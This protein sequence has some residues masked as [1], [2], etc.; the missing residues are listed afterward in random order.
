MLKETKNKGVKWFA[1]LGFL[2]LLLTPWFISDYL[3]HSGKENMLKN[4]H[5][6]P[7]S[8]KNKVVATI[9]YIF[10]T[11]V[12]ET[13]SDSLIYLATYQ[14]GQGGYGYIGL[15]ANAD[16]PE[17]H[18]L[19]EKGKQNQEVV[20]I[21]EVDQIEQT[22]SYAIEGYTD[23]MVSLL[24]NNGDLYVHFNK[25]HYLS[26]SK[27]LADKISEKM[28]TFLNPLLGICFLGIAFFIRR[29]NEAFYRLLYTSY[30]ELKDHL[31]LLVE[32][33]SYKDDKLGFL[34]YKDY[35]LTY[36]KKLVLIKIEDIANV[37]HLITN[38][39]QYFITVNTSSSFEIVKTNGKK[40]SFPIQ[41]IGA[42]TD[43][44]VYQFFYYLSETYPHIKIGQDLP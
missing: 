41:H 11:P 24:G 37:Y 17:I 30:P 9:T 34:I 2:I 40:L 23:H 3:H 12:F 18:D 43:M 33:A 28:Y 20:T 31:H 7:Q 26:R 27:F 38:Y 36:E 8:D 22:A 6:F 15:E 32:G 5:I 21:L 13:T 4:G 42:E 44:E 19:I 1:I 35:L 29:K 25:T 39:K 14:D 16:D 10:P